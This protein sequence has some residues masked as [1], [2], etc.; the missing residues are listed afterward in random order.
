MQVFLGL[1]RRLIQLLVAVAAWSCGFS[2]SADDLAV[3][4]VD[5]APSTGDNLYGVTAVQLWSQGGTI[6]SGAVEARFGDTVR[7]RVNNLPAWL[8]LLELD[9][10]V[11]STAENDAL[12]DEQAQMIRLFIG[13]HLMK[14]IP[15]LEY[16][17]DDPTWYWDDSWEKTLD[18]KDAKSAAWVQ[19]AKKMR[20]E[21]KGQWWL[22]F[23]LKR[24]SADQKSRDDWQQALTMAG[25]AP[26]LRLSIGLTNPN[27]T[28][29]H[30]M[31]SWV[32][33]GETGDGQD[34]ELVTIGWDAWAIWGVIVLGTAFVSFLF[35]A[36]RSG[37]L[38]DPTQ[39]IREDGLP[40]FSLGRCQM[41]FWFF[42]TAAAF[43]FLWLVTG[44]GDV[45]TINGTVL[46]LIGISAGTALGAAII[47]R[48]QADPV[49]AAVSPPVNYPEEIAKAKADLATVEAD[50][51]R[52]DPNDAPKLQANETDLH[53]KRS[54]VLELKR[55][56]ADW[57]KANW[58]QFLT[59]ILSDNQDTGGKRIITFHRFQIVI[60]SL[61]MGIVFVSEVLTKHAM[62]VFDSTLLTLMGIS[63]GTYLGF[64]LP[65]AKSS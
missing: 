45:N 3:I 11:N 14:T 25:R 38:R 36:F 20:D 10:T 21:A 16:F 30:V 48:N 15:I 23:A 65:A 13:D 55:K 29:A 50:R 56:L 1:W 49:A 34:F 47:S 31:A 43:Y 62:P 27:A 39:P 17:K 53:Q 40:P 24:D 64:K 44:R 28:F 5:Y 9:K 2:A 26:R 59:D 32:R 33:P 51:L 35:L 60:W 7:L 54:A 18:T 41:A 58:S 52:I 19:K 63:S 4:K 57:R 12:V 22:V 37:I 6:R 42:L 46:A 61:V 8:K